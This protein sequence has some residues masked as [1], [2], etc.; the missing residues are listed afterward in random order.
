MAKADKSK[1]AKK[2][3]DKAPWA[4]LLSQHPQ[5]GLYVV[6]QIEPSWV[7]CLRLGNLRKLLAF[8]LVMW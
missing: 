3:A 8:G 7:S 2:K 1:S 4:K 5:V 6:L